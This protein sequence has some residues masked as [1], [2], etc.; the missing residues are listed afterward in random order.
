MVE[1]ELKLLAQIGLVGFPNAGTSDL[2]TVVCAVVRV[3]VCA[4]VRS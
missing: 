3:C 2:S 4:C 1:L